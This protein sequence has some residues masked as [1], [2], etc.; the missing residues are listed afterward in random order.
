MKK[1]I[2]IIIIT[3]TL[4]SMMLAVIPA[5]AEEKG[6]DIVGGSDVILNKSA[7]ES[8]IEDAE[9]LIEK[10]YT[11][12]SW[13]VFKIVLASAISTLGADDQN[14]IDTATAALKLSISNLVPRQL[15]EETGLIIDKE[16]SNLISKAYYSEIYWTT[17]GYQTL[18]GGAVSKENITDYYDFTITDNMITSKAIANAP[19]LGYVSQTEYPITDDTFYVYEFKAKL[20]RVGGYAGV[21]YAAKGSEHYFFYGAFANDGDFSNSNGV[22]MSHL[23]HRYGSTRDQTGREFYECP[24][25]HLKLDEEGYG[26]W[27]VIYEGLTIKMQYL[28]ADGEWAYANNSQ[29]AYSSPGNQHQKD[30]WY[31]NAP[32]ISSFT[33][34]AGYYVAFGVQN[35]FGDVGSQRTIAVKDAVLYDCTTIDDSEITPADKTAL[36]AY[37][38]YV[39]EKFVSSIEYDA[40][41]WATF[42]KALSA[43]RIASG[44]KRVSQLKVDEK[45]EE[46]ISAVSAL[47]INTTDLDALISESKKLIE[48]NYTRESWRIFADALSVVERTEKIDYKTVLALYNDLLAAKKGLVAVDYSALERA[49]AKAEALVADKYTAESWVVFVQVVEAAKGA[50]MVPDQNMIDAAVASLNAAMNALVIYVE[51]EPVEKPTERPTEIP[52]EKPTEEATEEPMLPTV[53]IPSLNTDVIDIPGLSDIPEIPEDLS[54]IAG[55]GSTIGVSAVVVAVVLGAVVLK[56]KED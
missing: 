56:K 9:K 37:I 22:R 32:E 21:V 43:A 48:Y 53:D 14:E 1:A 17:L 50:L 47:K 8:A 6:T 28:T 13:A 26:S 29:R 52:T 27:R 55:C 20:N 38:K 44:N 41:T 51:D 23:Q 24:A 18:Y 45:L 2:S 3:A 35:K 25:L 40:E 54:A 34:P 42:Q 4:L 15:S 31:A 5:G 33:L 12:D 16:I 36:N 11:A 7:L 10:H 49:I 19:E 30:E 46:L 39:S